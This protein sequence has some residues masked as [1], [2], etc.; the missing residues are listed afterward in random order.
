MFP[1][2]QQDKRKH[3][4]VGW[5]FGDKTIL[6]LTTENFKLTFFIISLKFLIIYFKTVIKPRSW[7]Q[8]S[9][10]LTPVSSIWI[11]FAAFHFLHLQCLLTQDVSY[12]PRINW[13]PNIR[14]RER[15]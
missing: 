5:W 3:N 8:L 10:I 12:F 1:N 2:E 15:L 14:Q 13:K 9:P 6:V 7:E 4:L 11:A